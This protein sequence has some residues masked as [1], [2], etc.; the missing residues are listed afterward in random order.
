MLP[1]LVA[2]DLDDTLAPS[3]SPLPPEIADALARLLARTEVCIIS[4]G[5]VGQFEAQVLARLGD[6]PEETLARL[7]LM[8][9]CGTQY[10]RRARRRV[11]A[12]VRRAAR[13]SGAGPRD[14]RP[15]TARAAARLLGVQDVGSDHRGPRHRR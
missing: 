14:R 1:S 10:L 12:A 8:P 11:G 9:T 7:H 6:V 2:F 5:Q 15:R 4:G 3:K 13:A